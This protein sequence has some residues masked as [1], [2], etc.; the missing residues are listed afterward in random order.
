MANRF[1][2]R[3]WDKKNKCFIDNFYINNKG[4]L[5]KFYLSQT[6]EIEKVF[7]NE[8]DYIINQSIGYTDANNIEIYEGDIV[9]YKLQNRNVE[10]FII[11]YYNGSLVFKRKNRVDYCGIHCFVDNNLLNRLYLIG[12]IYENEELL[13]Y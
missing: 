11:E 4:L 9:A 6:E 3:V 2:F 12:N 5:V 13:N 7:L 8:E 1:N 10:H